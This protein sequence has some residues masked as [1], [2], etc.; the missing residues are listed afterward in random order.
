METILQDLRYTFRSLSKRLEAVA[1]RRRY[2]ALGV[3]FACILAPTSP[4][5]QSATATLSGAVMDA[6]GAVIPD[7]KITVINTATTQQRQTTTNSDGFFTLPLLPPGVYKLRAERQ[8]FATV[9]TKDLILNVGDQ[10]SLQIQL[11]PG[12]VSA[13]VDVRESASLTEGS[14]SVKTVV[15]RQFIANQPLNGRSFQT[16]IGLSPGVVFTPA[17]VVTQGQFSVNGQRP[18]VNYFTVDGVSAN[19]GVGASTTLYEGGGG[20]VPSFSAQG[21]TNSL[22]SAD[23][24][25]EFAIQTSTY[26][27]EFGRQ[28]G[29]QVSI[30]TRSGTNEF[31]GSIFNYLRND[32]LDANDY[33]ANANGLPRQA[34]RQNDFGFTLGGP[35]FLPRLGEGGK[36]YYDGRNRTFFFVSYEGLRLRQPIIS[37]PQIV[38]SLNARAAA[39]G[40]LRDILN[41]FPLP[42]GPAFPDAPDEAPFVGGYTNPSSLNATSVRVDHTVNNRLTLFGRYNHAP[43]ENNVRARFA[44]ASSVGL[45][46]AKTETLTAGATVIFSPRMSNELR[47]NYSRSRAAQTYI[48]DD[49]GGAVAPAE[50]SL[51]PAPFTRADGF[52]YIAADPAGDYPISDG[53]IS[54]NRQRQFNAVNNLSLNTGSHTLKFG[55]DYRR[56]APIA[57]GRSYDKTLLFDSVSQLVAGVAPFAEVS[58]FD[59]TLYPIFNNFSVFAQDTWRATPRLTLTYGLRYDINPAPTE[60]NGNLPLTVTG[61]DNLA[62]LALAPRG[63]RFYET[64]YNNI[65][66][67]VGFAYNISQSRGTVVRGGF[68]VFYDLGYTF[69]GSAFSPEFF[70]FARTIEVFDEPITSPIFFSSQPPPLNIEPPFP[71]LFAYERG[72]KL[73]Y[74]LQYSL[75]IEQALGA[76]SVVSVAY[77]GATGRRLGRV[78]SLRNPTEEFT[79]IDV[80]SNRA[81]SNYNA[82]QAQY[83]RRL[84]RG[85][86]ALA[87]YTFAKSID[88][89]SNES[90]LNFQAP[91]GRYD[92]EQDRGPSDFDVRHT[93]S[94]AM[95]FDIPTRFKRGIGHAVWGGFAVDAIYR[96]RTATPVNVLTDRDVL[97]LG[98]RTVSRPDVIPGVPVFID[99]P[100]EAGG[101]RINPAAFD[102]ASPTAARRQGTLGRNALRGFPL[103]QLDLSLRR[104]FALTER[105]NLQLRADAFNIFNRPN[106]A[107]PTGILSSSN[108]GRATQ[109]LNTGLRGLSSLYQ[110]GGPRSFQ[111]SLKLNF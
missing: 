27:P 46:P 79:R 89:A 87:S 96:A 108:F 82:F 11:R 90:I 94:G 13:T 105:V 60:K 19:F 53:F 74:T 106:F 56:L 39:T 63:S 101:R 20:G 30:V 72:Y 93:F 97:G 104:Q 23:A 51:F 9:D 41:A 85:V 38:P 42:T 2:L 67:R 88:T 73:P 50:S 1:D 71:R 33:F 98:F 36:D 61:L 28:P 103:S 48:Q 12:D 68:G 107:N 24:V 83:Q 4:L 52:V 15:D 37:P 65:A 78:E 31:R 92:P 70:P 29:A 102:A 59:A 10:R 109:M 45:L 55:A 18:S 86:Q 110:I 49:F 3:L 6:S 44:T 91:A 81:S 99:D 75:T 54:D 64:T 25:Q 16:L 17:N 34:L 69:A 111:M 57:Q 5:A 58:F 22:V 40:I 100:V 95:S 7:V 80:A 66:P 32:A 35:V 21:G 14:P 84:S 76:S 62:T 26:A 43:S 77:V 47:I 8:G